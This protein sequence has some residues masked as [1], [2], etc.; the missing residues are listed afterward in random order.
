MPLIL[1]YFY[2][3]KQHITVRIHTYYYCTIHYK[4]NRTRNMKF[5]VNVIL[6]ILTNCD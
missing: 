1:E 6:N 5:N 3:I 4:T 2:R